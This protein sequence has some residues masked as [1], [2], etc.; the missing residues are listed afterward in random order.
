MAP[1][2]HH[3]VTT[4]IMGNCG[5]GFAPVRPS[6]HERLVQLMEGVEDIPGAVLHEGLEWNWE[7]F[8]EYLDVLAARR[9]DMDVGTQLPHGAL[10]VFVMG[11]RGALRESAT[12]DDIAH[13]QRLTTEA[14]QAGALGCPVRAR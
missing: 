1:S 7:S 14:I 3:G 5:V 10:R 12:A 11:E 8:P 13:M 6:D 9:F 4:A 2:S